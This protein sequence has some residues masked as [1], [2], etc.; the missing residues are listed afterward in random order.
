MTTPLGG[1]PGEVANG[2]LAGQ[3]QAAC[4]AI[5]NVPPGDEAALRSTL[6]AW[7]QPYK[8]EAPGLFTGYYEPEVAGALT[9]SPAFPTP[10]L[11]R[12]ADLVQAQAPQSDPNGPPV[13]GRAVA[14][15][16]QPYWTRREIEAGAAG[17]AARPL[18]WL[19]NPVDLFFLQI[20]GSGRVRLPD[21]GVQ[22]VAFD[23]KNGQPYTPIGRALIARHALAPDQVSMQSIRA[24]LEAHPAEAKGVMDLNDDYVFFRLVADA[25]TDHGPPGAMGVLLTAGRS[26]AVDRH[27]IPLGAPLFLDTT[28][29]LT[30]QAWRRLVLAQDLGSDIK[31]AARTDVFLGAGD[32]AALLAGAMRQ[33]GTEYVLLPRPPR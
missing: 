2:S 20:Q 6:E 31:G 13:V 29:P 11:A 25:D 16:I 32:H 18:F 21:G 14:G 10:L 5:G 33:G 30:G 28:D 4:R 1:A 12:P 26:A 17:T 24:W 22:R 19:R 27:F 7:L 3:W 9:A 15:L 8:V 23:G